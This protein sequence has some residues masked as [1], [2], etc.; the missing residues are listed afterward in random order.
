MNAHKKEM[1]LLKE[2]P[3]QATLVVRL[4]ICDFVVLGLLVCLAGWFYD[5][6]WFVFFMLQWFHM[7]GM[8]Y[9]HKFC[10]FCF[11]L[12]GE[13]PLRD[14]RQ[15]ARETLC[16]CGV[17]KMPGFLSCMR[18]NQEWRPQPE[19]A[20]GNVKLQSVINKLS[21]RFGVQFDIRQLYRN[22][23]LTKY[24]SLTKALKRYDRKAQEKN[25]KDYE[26][27]WQRDSDFQTCMLACKPPRTLTF[28]QL[29]E[30]QRWLHNRKPL[31]PRKERLGNLQAAVSKEAAQQQ[32]AKQQAA[33]Q[34]VAW[35]N[36]KGLQPNE[37]AGEWNETSWEKAELHTE[38]M[39]TWQPAAYNNDEAE[40]QKAAWQNAAGQK[41]AGWQQNQQAGS[42]DK[43]TSGE[44]AKWH[45]CQWTQTQQPAEYDKAAWQNPAWQNPAW[46]RR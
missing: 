13:E 36:P 43:E 2:K 37:Q 20:M 17:P 6:S 21:I 23:F 35:Q 5:L 46:Q 39:Q 1:F 14:H 42:W 41:A 40:W 27:R 33:Q 28:R 11:G 22:P 30:E 7:F 24:S 19:Y 44:K 15:V 8:P 12:A 29:V 9:V 32:V 34:K 38:W 31:K 25:Y 4:I 26:D 10:I 45:T 3:H 18:C 16:N